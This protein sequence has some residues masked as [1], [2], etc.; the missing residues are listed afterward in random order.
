MSYLINYVNKCISCPPRDL[1]DSLRSSL[2]HSGMM[3]YRPKRHGMQV[4]CFQGANAGHADPIGT[5]QAQQRLQSISWIWNH[6]ATEIGAK[7]LQPAL[8]P[9]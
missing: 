1:V 2:L 6:M 4:V 7:D 9:H 8:K 5:Q 3:C